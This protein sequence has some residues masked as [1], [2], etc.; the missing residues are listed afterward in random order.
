MMKRMMAALLA[1]LTLLCGVSALAETQY[2]AW[3]IELRDISVT[4]DGEV[5][6]VTPSLAVRAGYTDEHDEAWLTVDVMKDGESLA[7]FRAEE[8]KNGASRYA[9]S[10]GET[11]GLMDGKGDARFH[12]LLMHELGISDAPDSLAEAID[13]LDAFLNMPKGVEYLFSQLGSIKK[14]G[15]SGYAVSVG[16]LGGR[17]EGV[18]SWKWERRAKKPFDFSGLRDV[19]YRQAEGI[20]GTEGFDEAEAELEDSLMQDE[21]MEELMIALMLLLES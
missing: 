9:Y 17:V 8:T 19:S 10:M 14:Q 3:T 6:D 15:K 13:M 5:I 21:S 12:K 20:R 1:L 18:L 7:G 16:L 11:C 4:A 2:G